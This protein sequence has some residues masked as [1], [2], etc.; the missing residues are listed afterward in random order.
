MD[1]NEENLFEL[2]SLRALVFTWHTKYFDLLPIFFNDNESSLVLVG[3]YVF[4]RQ[5]GIPAQ[6]LSEG[7]LI[8]KLGN[9]YEVFSP[10][11]FLSAA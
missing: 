2:K 11:D 10:R 8:I 1:L 3:G 5:Y 9:R 6:I 4:L 7:D